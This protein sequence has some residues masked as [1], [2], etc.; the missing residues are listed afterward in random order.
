MIQRIQSLYLFLTILLAVL[1]LAGNIFTFGGGTTATYSATV[2]GLFVVA[3]GTIGAP[4]HSTVPL[5]IFVLLT[6]L[7]SGIT[8]FSFRNRKL[9]SKLAISVIVLAVM[10]I[11]TSAYC[12]WFV[13]SEF[14]AQPRMGFKMILPFLMLIFA[15]LAYRGIKKDDNLV[16]SYDRLR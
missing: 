15:I 12:I 11:V 16:K 8:L 10:L 7:T 9:Q 6:T 4:V 1:F 5:T 2:K 14:Q 3:D 13:I